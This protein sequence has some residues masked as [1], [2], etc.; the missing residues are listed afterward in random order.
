MVVLSFPPIFHSPLLLPWSSPS[1]LSVVYYAVVIVVFQWAWASVQVS[2]LALVPELT[3]DN[4]ERVFL[5]SLRSVFTILSN[6]AVFLLAFFI[7]DSSAPSSASLGPA[8]LPS[9]FRLALLVVCIGSVFSLVFIAGV[10]EP[11]PRPK[12]VGQRRV[13]W[14]MW[15]SRL[16]FYQ[17][18]AIYTCTRL[19]VNVSQT[20]IPLFLL[21]TLHAAKSSIASV[22]LTVFGAGLLSTCVCEMLTR[23]L[24]SEVLTFC[25][26]CTVLVSCVGVWLIPAGHG[27][28]AYAIAFMLGS[29]TGIVGVSAL[30]LI[31]ELVG[32]CCESGAFVYGAMSFSDKI[33]NG[34]SSRQQ[35]PAAEASIRLCQPDCRTGSPCGRAVSVSV[36]RRG[37]HDSGGPDTCRSVQRVCCAARAVYGSH[38]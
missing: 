38:G 4:G 24:G 30:S 12:K 8:D 13:E 19:M 21:V 11:E 17:T 16:S 28:F 20:Y 5:N 23:R 14:W 35:R 31:C 7:L 9:F 22:P 26:C 25:G 29:G 32:D 34:S 33:A 10:P 18:A 3:R 1:A 27:G 36:C 15:F 2:H 6:L 37:H